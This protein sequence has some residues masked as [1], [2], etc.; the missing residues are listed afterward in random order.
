MRRHFIRRRRKPGDGPRA[1]FAGR[2]IRFPRDHGTYI[3][4][5]KFV[6]KAVERKTQEN[7]IPKH[8]FGDFAFSETLKKNIAAHGYRQ[9]TPIQ[10]EAI[11]PILQGRDLIGLAN[12]GTGKTASFVLPILERLANKPQNEVAVLIIVPT[13]ELANQIDEEIRIFSW[14]L[15]IYSTLCVGG[16]SLNRQISS[17][18]RRPQIVIGTPGRLKD[19][20]GQGVLRLAQ[21][22][23]LVL[24]EADRMLDMGFI[25]DIRFLVG[26]LPRERQ[27]LCFSATM[28]AD[29]ER[30]LKGF[31]IDPVT[32]SVRT[33]ISSE[34]IDQDV[35]RA[36]TEE[37]K[38]RILDDLLRQNG[39]EKILIFGRTKW[40]VQKLADRL[41]KLGH[42]AEAIHGNKSQPQRQRALKA[43][44]EDKV[45]VL[46]ATDVAARGLDI[47]DV[48]H[49]IN[50]DQ[51]NT[52]GDYIHRIGRTARAGK[53]GKAL[54]FVSG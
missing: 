5:D 45:K 21:V 51:P 20:H 46:V 17:L 42:S 27:S 39:F 25:R 15:N 47:P 37:Q 13:R 33:G 52:Y 19:L 8:N 44:K 12:T 26:Q 4:P 3:H 24:D 43:F 40:G 49:V 6:N 14:G 7:F 22:K 23:V 2:P 10:D 48:S 1:T 32:V 29:I 53:Q 54:T 50:F 28:P 31:M 30:L 11:P 18:R 36:S 41:G 16:A 35:I 34:F 9:P 38:I